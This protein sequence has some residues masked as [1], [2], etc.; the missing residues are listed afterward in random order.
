[1]ID[2]TSFSH[3]VFKIN[4][5]VYNSVKIAG[6]IESVKINSE[7]L[8]YVKLSRNRYHLAFEERKKKDE[9]ARK[10]ENEKK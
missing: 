9:A 7:I 5:T 4:R 10:L 1:M 6:G 8:Q 3:L 2:Y